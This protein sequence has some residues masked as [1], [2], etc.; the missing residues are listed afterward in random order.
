[1][2]IYS[3]F[4]KKQIYSFHKEACPIFPLCFVIY[5][6]YA[7]FYIFS[8]IKYKNICWNLNSDRSSWPGHPLQILIIHL[9]RL[10]AM[11]FMIWYLKY[12]DFTMIIFYFF[13]SSFSFFLFNVLISYSFT[14]TNLFQNTLLPP[15]PPPNCILNYTCIE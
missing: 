15:P 10:F 8:G 13:L 5:K 3:W 1:M 4:I 2:V 6:F 12:V 14:V 9:D 7:F 11:V